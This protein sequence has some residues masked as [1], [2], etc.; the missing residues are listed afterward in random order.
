MPLTLAQLLTRTARTLGDTAGDHWDP[1]EL[2]DYLNDGLLDFASK[3][4]CNQ[5]WTQFQTNPATGSPAEYVP[6]NSLV[7]DELCFLQTSLQP[8]EHKTIEEACELDLLWYSNQGTPAYYLC[9]DY[10]RTPDPR[11]QVVFAFPVPAAPLTDLYGKITT[12]PTAM[13]YTQG[14]ANGDTPDLPDAYHVALVYYA[15]WQAYDSDNEETR[16][17]RYAA[18][19]QGK[20]LAAVAE[21]KAKA[22]NQFTRHAAQ[23]APVFT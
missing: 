23:V 19:F 13:A 21:A 22:D 11:Q 3:T 9:G 20:Y 2:A 18:K 16:D 10:A 12:V 1:S 5:V 7:M 4:R 17:E 15:C 6:A 14:G 8:L